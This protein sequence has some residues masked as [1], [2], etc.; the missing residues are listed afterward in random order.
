MKKSVLLRD[1]N[2]KK[3]VFESE[4][5]VLVDFWSSWCTPCKMAE[6]V[7]DELATDLDGKIKVGKINVDQNSQI[8]GQLGI[9]G[10]PTF[11]L[12]K[13]GKALQ[14]EV[15]ARSKQQLLRL[16]EERLNEK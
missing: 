13:E 2:F 5:P 9:A 8:A 14:R 11:I 6:P 4:V 7:I 3:E 16:I 15:G 1:D 10:V 12:F